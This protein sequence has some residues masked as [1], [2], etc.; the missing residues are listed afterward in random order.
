MKN[1]GDKSHDLLENLYD[2][3]SIVVMMMM[4]MQSFKQVE[5]YSHRQLQILFLLF[6]RGIRMILG[7]KVKNI[8]DKTDCILKSLLI[9]HLRV[10]TKIYIRQ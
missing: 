7:K 2:L 1:T 3:Q 4:M 6:R 10:M 9:H 5:Y 8:G